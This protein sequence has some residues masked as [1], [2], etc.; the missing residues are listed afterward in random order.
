MRASI[1][2]Q[3]PNLSPQLF[4]IMASNLIIVESPAKCRTIQKYLGQGWRVEASFGHIRDLPP[5]DM[6]VD[7]ESFEPSY[8]VSEGSAKTIRKLKEAVSQVDVVWLASDP[9]RE[10]EAIAW[11]LQQVLKRKSHRQTYHR[12]SFNEITQQAVRAAVSNPRQID[13][14]KVDSQQG[15]RILDRLIGWVVSPALSNIT[16][17]KMAAGRVQSP[18]VRL[19]KEREDLIKVFEKT[20]HFGVELGFN[21][22]NLAWKAQWDTKPFIEND[23]IP[24][25]TDR[26]LA[27]SVAEITDVTVRSNTKKKRKKSAPAPFIT[28]S[29]QQSGSNALKF[30]PKKTMQVAQKLY[31]AG[32]ITYMRTDNPNL[33]DD[34][35][36]ML[37][38]YMSSVGQS[39]LMAARKNTWK[40]AG[41]AQE[42]HEAIRCTDFALREPAGL[43]REELLLYK[44]IR[45]RAI[46]SQMKPA[47][48]EDHLIVLEGNRSVAK[49][50]IKPIFKAKSTDVLFKGWLVATKEYEQENLDQESTNPGLPDLVINTQLTADYSLV[51]ALATKPPRRYTE[52][53]LAKELEKRGIGRPSTFA[54]IID[55]IQRHDFVGIEKR[56][57]HM[58][59]KGNTLIDVMV[60]QLK[61]GF[62]E[63]QYTR[64]IELELDKIAQQKMAYANLMKTFYKELQHELSQSS[65]LIFSP[66]N[67]PE[68]DK[69]LRQIKGKKSSDVFW[70]CTGY[71]EGCK[72]AFPDENGEPYIA[73]V[74]AAHFCTET[75]SAL[76]RKKSKQGWFWVNTE[77]TKYYDDDQG[78]P[79]E[80]GSLPYKKAA[81]RKTKTPTRPATRGTTNK[82]AQATRKKK[83]SSSPHSDDGVSPTSKPCT[84]C[85]EPMLLRKGKSPKTKKAY[86]FWGCSAY[87][88]CTATAS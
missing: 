30:S 4:L 33:S 48:Y 82:K 56:F 84:E 42:A 71:S 37:N 79:V 53:S 9:D 87:P 14:A 68:C 8:Q 52:A 3:T 15:R 49:H 43:K 41:D 55:T 81:K 17:L 65:A 77:G 32:L 45:S 62:V 20:D 21:H 73:P 60:G 11:H 74:N 2:R 31:E 36:R 34:A 6:G 10:G 51:K 57:F 28:I 5:K 29:L 40:G 7:L 88:K 46:A 80:K 26:G 16:G 75:Q 85:G 59:P 24:Y 70:G 12:I 44:M 18:A 54:S 58:K 76:L 64:N 39:D 1:A 27:E 83:S 69:P 13:M 38:E 78:K 66:F 72:G 63:Y 67:C 47:V 50:N 35:F 19:I 25:I 22:D 23:D 86:E 61:L